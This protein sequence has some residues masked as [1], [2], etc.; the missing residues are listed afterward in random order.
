[1]KKLEINWLLWIQGLLF[2]GAAVLVFKAV[3]NIDGIFDG[4]GIFLGIISPII[5]A[6]AIAYMLSRPCKWVEK[7]LKRAKYPFVV[8]RARGLAILIVYS[9]MIWIIYTVFR[10]IFPLLVANINDFISFA[11]NLISDIEYF[12]TGLDL[13]SLE[14]VFDIQAVITEIFD[15]FDIQ[16]I[17]GPVTQGLGVITNVAISTAFWLFDFFLALIISIYMLLYKDVIFETFGRIMNLMMRVESATTLKYYAKQADDLFYK[18]IG[19]QFL[20]SCIMAT[21][22]IVLLMLLNVRFAVFL[23]IFLGVANMIPKFG[24]IIASVVVIALTFLTGDIRQ[25]LW[26][27]VLLTAVQQFDG[28]V[29][30]PMIMGDALKINPV[31]VFFSLLVGAQFGIMGMF[32]SIPIMALIKIITMNIIEAKENSIQ[33]SE[34]IADRILNPQISKTWQERYREKKTTKKYEESENK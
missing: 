2:V 9:L 8:K 31:L 17:I 29:I 33:H 3:M 28:N 12:I 34:K 20:D 11:P 4:V 30:G 10:L 22:S 14:E 18:F 32:L 27:A 13:S 15:D 19:A 23:G 6:A 21:M 25:G 7:W 26:T 5:M 1:M 16:N 24:S